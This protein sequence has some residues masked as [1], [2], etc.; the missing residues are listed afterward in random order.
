MGE[1]ARLVV[2]LVS[3]KRICDS[4]VKRSVPI[5]DQELSGTYHELNIMKKA[6]NELVSVKNKCRGQNTARTRRRDK[7]RA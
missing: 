6:C 2:C 3:A 1:Q 5:Y 4:P 7:E